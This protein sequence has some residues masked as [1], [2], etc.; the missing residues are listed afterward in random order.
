MPTSN[1]ALGLLG[2]EVNYLFRFR[3]FALAPNERVVPLAMA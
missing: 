1:N 3:S 2:Q